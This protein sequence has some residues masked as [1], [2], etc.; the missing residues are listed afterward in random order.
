[1][2]RNEVELYR[3]CEIMLALEE[4]SE[5]QKLYS[6][7][8]RGI[9]YHKVT[10]LSERVLEAVPGEGESMLSI[11]ENDPSFVST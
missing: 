6:I 1:M 4:S 9:P 11:V 7:L 3:A 5:F 2:L 8:T 10:L